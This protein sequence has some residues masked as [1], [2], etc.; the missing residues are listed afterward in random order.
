MSTD[1]ESPP[2]EEMWDRIRT[3]PTNKDAVIFR[4]YLEEMIRRAGVQ[5]TRKAKLFPGTEAVVES[6]W[7]SYFINHAPALNLNTGVGEA[8]LAEL[9]LRITVRH[10]NKWN[11]YYRVK[12]RAACVVP[13]ETAEDYGKP[14]EAILLA[15]LCEQLDAELSLRQKQIVEYL[16]QGSYTSAE[17]SGIFK[18][19][20]T[21]IER[22]KGIIREKTSKLIHTATP[23]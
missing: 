2:A 23:H 12:K 20:V 5:L 10:C 17:L 15:E 4:E 7:T 21:T 6:A 13:L 3:S 16:L 18:V 1:Q 19:S 22:E 14:D 11:S 8:N 9:L